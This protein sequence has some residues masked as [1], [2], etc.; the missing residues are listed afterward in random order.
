M[1]S[2]GSM[3]VDNFS[4]EKNFVKLI[5]RRLT[6]FSANS[7]IGLIVFSDY[8]RL[9]VSFRDFERLGIDGFKSQVDELPYQG[10]RSRIDLSLL[11]ASQEFYSDGR[12]GVPRVSD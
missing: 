10:G 4:R 6:S 8:P 9:I 2:S 12:T 5:S 11:S 7:R 3:G 1:D